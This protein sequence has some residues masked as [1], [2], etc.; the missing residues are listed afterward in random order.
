MS[1]LVDQENI[2]FVDPVYIYE[3]NNKIINDILWHDKDYTTN[4]GDRLKTERTLHTLFSKLNHEKLNTNMYFVETLHKIATTFQDIP[5]IFNKALKYT[6]TNPETSLE[7][8]AN[9]VSAY[10]LYYGNLPG[11]IA[12]KFREYLEKNFTFDKY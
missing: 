12:P 8:M 3:L 4:Q 6:V 11:D 2:S 9:A 5:Y 10:N 1:F 7:R